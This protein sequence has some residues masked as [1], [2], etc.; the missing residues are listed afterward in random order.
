MRW[1][2]AQQ[3]RDGL[4]TGQ[5]TVVNALAAEQ[6]QAEHIPG[7]LNLWAD[8]P[9]FAD[10]AAELLPDRKTAIVVHCSG[11]PG[12]SSTK[13]AERLKELGYRNVACFGAG[14][15]GWRRAGFPLAN[16]AGKIG[17]ITTHETT[18][19]AQS[20]TATMRR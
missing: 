12:T 5:A 19:D 18:A 11:P 7:S 1:V 14:I 16:A 8:D 10:R 2:D 4:D 15:E 6:Y 3:V 20:T 13:T 17:G 9:A